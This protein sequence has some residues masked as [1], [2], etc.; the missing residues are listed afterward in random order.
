[1]VDRA[2]RKAVPALPLLVLLGPTSVGKTSVSLMLARH[3]AGE[4]VS[5]DSRL[6]YRGMDVGTAKPT[7][8][9][10]EAVPHHLIDITEP[11]QP[12]SLALYQEL[13]YAAIEGILARGR[14]P[15]LVGGTGQYVWAVVE[16]WGIPRVSPQP[17]LRAALLALGQDEASRWLHC[18]DPEAADRIDSRNLRR[19]VRA[20]EVTLVSGRPISQLQQK[21]KPP[22]HVTIVGLT[23]ERRQL[24]ARIDRRVDQ[25]MATGLLEEVRALRAA[26]Y[27]AR[28]PAMSSLGYRELWRYLEGKCS[29]EEA[30]ERIKFETHRFARQQYTWFRLDDSRIRWFDVDAAGVETSIREYVTDR[31]FLRGV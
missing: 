23:C 31:L 19:V 8:A 1:M 22:H 27:D 2:R 9:E 21:R 18:L 13:A 26:G 14:L 16:G 10:R 5:A 4:I 6:I 30:V 12:F 3:F 25:M 7:P 24:Y 20:L 11:D 29:L 28:L 17:A 15:I